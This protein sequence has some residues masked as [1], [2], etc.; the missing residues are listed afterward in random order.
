MSISSTSNS[1]YSIKFKFSFLIV[2]IDTFFRLF[3]VEVIGGS[4]KYMATC[5][6]CFNSNAKTPLFP[7]RM[8]AYNNGRE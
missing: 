2:F 6:R 5:R 8:A 1:T 3:Q 7:K 4:D